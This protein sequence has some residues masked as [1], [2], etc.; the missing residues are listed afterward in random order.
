[1]L[2]HE[3]VIFDFLLKKP[4]SPSICQK[5]LDELLVKLDMKKLA[6]VRF[7]DA[8]DLSE[9]GFS[10]IQPITTSHICGH[11]FST[12]QQPHHLHL[13]IY[14]CKSFAWEEVFEV[15]KKNMRLGEWRGTKV[16]RDLTLMQTCTDIKGSGDKII[17][18]KD[19]I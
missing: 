18:C 9:P 17:F 1:M 12:E 8:L 6:D 13:D 4:I 11:Y 15:C 3:I 16:I 14:S 5:L 2:N 10:F 7:Y 19:L